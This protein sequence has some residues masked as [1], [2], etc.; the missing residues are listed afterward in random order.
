MGRYTEEGKQFE[1]FKGKEGLGQLQK[2][3]LLCGTRMAYPFG[4]E[5]SRQLEI[6][7]YYVK[8]REQIYELVKFGDDFMCNEYD[9]EK[10]SVP[11]NIIGIG[12][13]DITVEDLDEMF[14]NWEEYA[15][16]LKPATSE[17]I[18]AL[19]EKYPELESALVIENIFEAP[20]GL[21]YD[22]L[23]NQLD[24]LH[25]A[26]PDDVRNALGALLRNLKLDGDSKAEDTT[27]TPEDY[28]I[29]GEVVSIP[30]YTREI[31]R[32]EV[33]LVQFSRGVN[34]EIQSHRPALVISTDRRNATLGTIMCLAIH[35]GKVKY[36]A[37]QVGI[38]PSDVV[39]TGRKQLNRKKSRIELVDCCT[40]DRA[41][42][43]EKFGDL[44]PDKMQEVLEKFK[45][46]Y[47]L[48]DDRIE[49]IDLDV[50]L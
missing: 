16:K 42:F 38:V 15:K 13:C 17:N 18:D 11:E 47:E 3:K 40:L 43:L 29:D 9:E 31:K 39:Y 35:S 22:K 14:G 33:W 37:S 34:H 30:T 45:K 46:Y 2:I 50:F 6:L 10:N 1:L 4:L 26:N 44:N 27:R 28:T 25:T 49:P 19:V 48:P 20:A 21:T 24:A 5:L 7:T 36:P 8:V 12:N 23:K 41:R 32:G